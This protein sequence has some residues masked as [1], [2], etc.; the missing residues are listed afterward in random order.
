MPV[1]HYPLLVPASALEPTIKF[2][3]ESLGHLGFHE[4]SRP[5]AGVVGLG[6]T[7]PYFWIS[8]ISGLEDAALLPYL[9]KAHIA[10]A[11]ENAQQVRDFHAAALKAGGTDNG[12]PGLREY[13]GPGYYGAFIKDPLLGVNWEV[14][15]RNGEA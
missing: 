6:E 7:T 15:S 2:L 14:V 12:A 1:D 13:Y 5:I 10:F 4:F 9:G 11:A 8:A 3:V